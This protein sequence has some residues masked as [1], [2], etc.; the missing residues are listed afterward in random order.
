MG[1]KRFHYRGLP[2]WL[3]PLEKAMRR[4]IKLEWKRRQRLHAKDRRV[5]D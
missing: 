3:K 5:S 4:A 1:L 2:Q